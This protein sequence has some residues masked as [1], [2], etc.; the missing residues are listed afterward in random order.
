MPAVSQAQNRWAHAVA[1][2]EVPGT[3]RSV[4]REFITDTPNLPKRI[5]PLSALKA[6]LTTMG[7]GKRP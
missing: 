6:K 3:P 7:R 2:G 5:H 4:G 1:E